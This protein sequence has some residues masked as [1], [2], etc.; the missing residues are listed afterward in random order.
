MNQTVLP[1]F[2]CGR[3]AQEVDKL[4]SEITLTGTVVGQFLGKPARIILQKS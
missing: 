3:L 1:V 4:V 2:E